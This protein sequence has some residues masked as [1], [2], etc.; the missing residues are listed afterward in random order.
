MTSIP[1]GLQL[2][3]VRHELAED[4]EG[5]LE[6]VAK[7]GYTAVEFFGPP[8]HTAS[9]IKKM[10]DDVGLQCCGWHTPY[11]LVQADTLDETIAFNQT[12]NNDKV[13]IPGI[14]AELRTSRADWLKLASA[15]NG[16]ADKLAEHNMVTGYH[17]HNIEFQ[18]M[19]GENPWDTFFSNTQQ[20]VIMQLD[21]G[22]GILG[23]AEPIGLI[24]K[25]AGRAVTVHLKPYS[26]S[27]AKEAGDP[28]AGFRPL[29]G[30][31]ETDW[32]GFF[33][34]CESV[35]GTEWYIVEYE[36]DAYPALE[37]VDLC[38]KALK[39]MGK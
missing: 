14:P 34:A 36:S 26:H 10:L 30:D 38:L 39:E 5:T 25:Y 23:G 11:N 19:E 16:V 9:E 28:H 22:N 24:Q 7:M 18:P 31:D 1:I 32:A 15:V 37:A 33:Q 27:A 3:S 4:I 21:T 13:I 6:A 20:P 29:I 8:R 35:G 17:N 2:F 12:L